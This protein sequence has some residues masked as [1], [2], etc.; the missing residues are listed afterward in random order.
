MRT[1]L[2]RYSLGIGAA[3]AFL[4][5]CGQTVPR[6]PFAGSMDRFSPALS[7]RVL[8]RFPNL[9]LGA[10]PVSDLINMSGTLY[11]STSWGDSFNNGTVFSISTSGHMKVLHSFRDVPDGGRPTAGLIDVNGVLYGTTSSGGR[12]GN[13]GFSGGTVY[14]ITTSGT[15]KVL[16]RFAGSSD[17]WDPEAG[18]VDLGGVLYG[19]TAQGGS[20]R[21]G[22][23]GT[24]YSI[25]TSGSHKVLYCFAGGSDGAYPASALI[26]VAGTLYG[27]TVGGG[28]QGCHN[29]TCGTVY[30]IT[31]SGTEKVLHR[32]GSGKDGSNPYSGLTDVNGALYGTTVEGGGS[33]SCFSGGG[34]GTVFRITTAG[35]E[36]VLH[37][38]A[39]GSD[40]AEARASLIDVN[41]MLY[42]ATVGGGVAAAGTVYRINTAGVEKVLYSFGGRSDGAYP[43]AGVTSLKGVLYGTTAAGGGAGCGGPGRGCGTAFALSP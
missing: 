38:F 5:S 30:S 20:A 6:A 14:S 11:G 24:V 40:G 7:Y 36:K 28:H 33:G 2:T 23:C 8:H 31:R 32:F 35:A 43:L 1:L 18:L 13:D 3:A 19:T 25:T 17:G 26:D 10:H 16:Y 39:G 37:S 21:F 4:A 9:A 15:E 12:R 22:C 34:C 41:G 27:T 42:G 29:G